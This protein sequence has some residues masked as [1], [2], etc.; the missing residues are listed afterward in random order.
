MTN[1][2]GAYRRGVVFNVGPVLE[3]FDGL[4]ARSNR[5][6]LENIL[7]SKSAKIPTLGLPLDVAGLV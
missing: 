6:A 7:L 5:R 1:I 2:N 3:V 4:L